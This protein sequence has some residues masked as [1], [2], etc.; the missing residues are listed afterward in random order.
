M[1]MGAHYLMRLNVRLC[2]ASEELRILDEPTVFR[3]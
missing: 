1:D 2:G 3:K